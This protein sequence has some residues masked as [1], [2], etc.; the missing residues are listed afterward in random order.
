[1]S[2]GTRKTRWLALATGWLLMA[3]GTL[4]AAGSA[5]LVY[6][7]QTPANGAAIAVDELGHVY[8]S[9]FHRYPHPLPWVPPIG[10]PSEPPYGP[11]ANMDGDTFIVGHDPDGQVFYR[12]FV[13][14]PAVD[15]ARVL[16]AR[17]QVIYLLREELDTE[18]RWG[19][20]VKLHAHLHIPPLSSSFVI[21]GHWAT[22]N[23]M[24]VDSSGAAYVT[25]QTGDRSYSDYTQ[26]NPYGT[27][28]YVTKVDAAGAVHPILEL[29]GTGYDVGLAIDVDE[30][31]YVYVTGATFS[32]DFPVVGG[33]STGERFVAKLDPSGAIV[34]SIRLGG[35]WGDILEIAARDG[36]VSLVGTTSSAAFPVTPG[37]LD[38]TLSGSRDP[39]LAR[40]DA[41]GALVY[42]TYLGGEGA[43]SL[44][45]AVFGPENS[46]YLAGR[47][48]APGSPLSDPGS[49][50]CRDNFVARL[51]LS[52]GAW[53]S[54]CLQGVLIEGLAVH[55]SGDAYVNG[56]ISSAG[57]FPADAARKR[58][59]ARI[60]FN[61]PPDCSVAF[62]SPATVWPPSGRLV[63]VSISGVTDPDGD[64]VTVTI[65]GVRQDEPL[66]R[67]GTP[68]AIGV[69]TASVS[70]RA[71]RNGKGDGRAYHVR[72]EARDS[73]GASC[74]G[75]VS[76]CVPHDRRP[77]AACGDGGALFDSISG[78]PVP[79][80][81]LVEG[82]G[83]VRTVQEAGALTMEL[84]LREEN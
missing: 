80:T 10:A 3:A 34:Y 82:V 7:V 48:H 15:Y 17:S 39:Y 81:Y 84:R 61:A 56:S 45:G 42:A 62:A 66:S 14:G 4:H 63:P 22:V 54:T 55:A 41:S 51:N 52:S 79:V 1:M 31:G 26:T 57:V 36:G 60:A 71:D 32:P 23:D 65:T 78:G 40:L 59:V 38:P 47:G 68:D 33:Q 29:D 2:M 11:H 64:P 13:P 24:A 43:E 20:V 49:P 72:F 75:T 6:A 30:E 18:G 58:F 67:S 5:S 37:A 12:A 69:G 27:A 83:A 21:Y 8:V 76:L 19:D 77:G 50:G 28:A 70:V 53:S 9:G 46:L 44:A 16:I 74:T 25:G 73:A 35:E